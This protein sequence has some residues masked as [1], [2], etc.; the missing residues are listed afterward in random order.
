MSYWFNVDTH[1]VETDETR[2]PDPH[3]LGPYE[4]YEDAAHALEKARENTER[5]DE[6]DKEWDDRANG[7]T[8]A[9]GGWDGSEGS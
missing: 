5:W 4:T 1:A 6:E 8:N 7:D 2:S 9:W 3:V